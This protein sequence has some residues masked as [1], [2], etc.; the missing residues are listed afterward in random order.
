MVK[1]SMRAMD[2]MTEFVKEKFPDET[3]SLD[4]YSVAGA[5]K[6]GWTTW[7][8]AAVDSGR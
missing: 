3:W 4:Y 5:S 7:D 2:A 6:R 8:V 1:A